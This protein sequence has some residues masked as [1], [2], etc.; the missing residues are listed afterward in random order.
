MLFSCFKDYCVLKRKKGKFTKWFKIKLHLN[1]FNEQFIVLTSQNAMQYNCILRRSCSV[2]A[3]VLTCVC[4][5]V[6]MC[7]YTC[8]YRYVVTQCILYFKCKA[9]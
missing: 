8:I 4:V 2:Q 9:I 1:I 7:A 5:C 3:Q 6:C